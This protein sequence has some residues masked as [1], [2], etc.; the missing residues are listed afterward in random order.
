MI[1]VVKNTE[2]ADKRL[3]DLKDT[4][5]WSTLC[6]VGVPE[7]KKSNNEVWEISEVPITNPQ[8]QKYINPICINS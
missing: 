1:K 5:R 6:L 4:K 3:K 8:S 2:N 7:R